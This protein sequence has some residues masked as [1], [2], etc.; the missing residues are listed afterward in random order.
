MTRKSRLVTYSKRESRKRRDTG[1][2][3]SSKS[4]S[5]KSKDVKR[6]KIIV[7]ETSPSP[8]DATNDSNSDELIIQNVP[9]Q[10]KK[11]STFIPTHTTH[12]DTSMDEPSDN[13]V[14]SRTT[15]PGRSK[16]RVLKQIDDNQEEVTD[17][18]K[19]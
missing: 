3:S 4:I 9:S 2:S 18:C 17:A 15:S 6:P 7:H 10:Q 11:L 19:L 8:S 5:K 1:F 14:A 12:V 13:I 16:V